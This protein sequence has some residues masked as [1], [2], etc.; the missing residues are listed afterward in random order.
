M[1]AK[2]GAIA[3]VLGDLIFCGCIF[4]ALWRAGPGRELPAGPF[5]R[6]AL[7]TVPAVL[8]GILSPLPAGADALLAALAFVLA[9]WF[10]QAV[11][12]E[13]RERIRA[14]RMRAG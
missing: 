2:G 11:P 13:I 6:L 4:A 14:P 5:L 12:E 1:G 3:A 8:I 7:A 9:A 10:A